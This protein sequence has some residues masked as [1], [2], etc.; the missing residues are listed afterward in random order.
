MMEAARIHRIWRSLSGLVSRACAPKRGRADALGRAC[1][2]RRDTG[3]LDIGA[4]SL[5]VR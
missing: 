5:Y 4:F 3:G 1:H 2:Q